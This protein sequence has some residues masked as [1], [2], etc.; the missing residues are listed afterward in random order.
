MKMKS[1]LLTL[2]FLLIGTGSAHAFTDV[3]EFMEKVR[4]CTPF[5]G[6]LSVG[7]SHVIKGMKE[8][9]CIIINQMTPNLRSECAHG[10]EYRE[11]QASKLDSDR[12]RAAKEFA[13]RE[14]KVYRSSKPAGY[15][16][17]EEL[18]TD[19]T[20]NLK[21]CTPFLYD[22]KELKLKMIYDRMTKEHR[23]MLA[24]FTKPSKMK[25]E[26]IGE[27]GDKCVV[28]KANRMWEYSQCEH[29]QEYADLAYKLYSGRSSRDIAKRTTALEKKECSAPK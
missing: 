14:C 25:I 1:L 24:K 28:N 23:E 29:S 3:L 15:K 11:L 2:C 22:G 7:S 18:M 16:F 9:K 5:S 26:I 12:T 21:T 19:Y 17:L 20:H 13:A 8:G 10:P 4:T 6:K 27:K